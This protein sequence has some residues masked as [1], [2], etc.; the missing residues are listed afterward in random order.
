MKKITTGIDSNNLKFYYT[1]SEDKT[2]F[3]IA[4]RVT[5]GNLTSMA[6]AL[7]GKA[8]DNIAKDICEEEGLESV[9]MSGIDFSCE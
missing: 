7:T 2:R 6:F 8:I 3:N 5:K 4:I 9:T 1:L